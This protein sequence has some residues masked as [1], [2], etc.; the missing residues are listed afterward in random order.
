MSRD[1]L[2]GNLLKVAGA[3]ALLYLA[4]K[5]GEQHANQRLETSPQPIQ[6]IPME[7]VVT[8]KTEEENVLELIRELRNKSNKTK[9]DKYNIELLEIKLKQIRAQ[10]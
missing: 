7:E 5:L 9:N 4:Y 6:D 2:F 10:K 1:G 3:G 8:E